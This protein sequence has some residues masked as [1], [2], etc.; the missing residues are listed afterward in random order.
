M[1]IGDGYCD[2]NN[3]NKLCAYDGNDCCLE[4]VLTNYC[5]ICECIE[6]KESQMNRIRYLCQL[7][8]YFSHKVKNSHSCKYV[9]TEKQ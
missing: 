9:W 1:F 8:F 7:K 3:N 5:T 2:D 6:G 4:N